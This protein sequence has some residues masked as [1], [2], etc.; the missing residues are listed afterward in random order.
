MHRGHD[1][2]HHHGDGGHRYDANGHAPGPGHNHPRPPA[3]AQ[4]QTPHLAHSHAP[5]PVAGEPDLD[6]VEAAFVEGFTITT[7]ATSFLRLARVPFE[8]TTTDGAKLALLRVEVEALTD[9]GAIT[10]HLG[11]GSFRYDPLPGRIASR[12]RRLRFIYFDGK[13]TRAL[14]LGG[15]REL[16]ES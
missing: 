9:V 13:A 16:S 12:R 11:G 1:H 7:D 2:D 4:W 6:L 15:V 3:T 8:A 10:P 14:T 5:E